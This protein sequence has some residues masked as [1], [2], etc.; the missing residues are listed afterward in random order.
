MAT[1][2][3]T[4]ATGFIGRALVNTLVELGH[5]VRALSRRT[6]SDLESLAQPI[7][8][9]LEDT[10]SLV[11]LVSGAD[12]V[13][14]LAGATAAIDRATYFKTNAAGTTR[15]LEAIEANT[16]GIPL[17]SVSSLAAREPELSH[18][19]S[20]KRAGETL[21]ESARTPWTIL[22]PPAVYGPGDA[23]LS[24]LWALLK[25]GW[26]PQ[27]GPREGRFSLIYVDDLAQAIARLAEHMLNSDPTDRSIHRQILDIDD[28]FMGELG[29]GYGWADIA[30]IAED[31]FS[32][33]PTVVPIPPLMLKA[34]AYGSEWIGRLRH[35]PAIFN[36]G[37]ASELSHPD[38]VAKQT[39][40]WAQLGWTPSRQLR[41]TLAY[42]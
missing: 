32:K 37:K 8:G 19:A 29:P 41:D 3:V 22:R 12:A 17:V 2:A 20:S 30:S 26:L 4:G 16:A 5:D 13:I 42:L 1:F 31:V 28:Q 33:R 15:L 11:Q 39:P 23:G 27:I 7:L 9:T 10:P 40:H 34:M 36:V 35:R 21:V 14:H 25:H 6:K 24:P 18:Y 38:W